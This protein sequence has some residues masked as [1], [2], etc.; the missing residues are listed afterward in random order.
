MRKGGFPLDC[1]RVHFF[2]VLVSWCY[3]GG[4]SSKVGRPFPCIRIVYLTMINN[5]TIYIQRE[6]STPHVFRLR[7]TISDN[8]TTGLGFVWYFRRI[9]PG[10]HASDEFL[11]GIR[12]APFLQH[13]SYYVIWVERFFHFHFQYVAL[14]LPSA[15][16]EH[17]MLCII[18]GFPAVKTRWL[19]QFLEPV[20]MARRAK[21]S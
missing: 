4:T 10:L 1:S 13:N 9:L 18:R 7:R 14:P 20:N 5:C 2:F 11:Y 12:I 8:L 3:R 21:I 17:D 16:P 19:I 6:G 15:T